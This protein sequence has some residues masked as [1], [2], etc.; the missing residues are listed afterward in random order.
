MKIEAATRLKA[1]DERPMFLPERLVMIDCEMTGLDP[2]TDDLLQVA[3]IKLV[4][5][6][7]GQGYAPLPLWPIFNLYIRTDKEPI[8]AFALEHM[9]EVYEKC[10]ASTYT[11]ADA[12]PLLAQWMSGWANEVSPTG[13]CVS[14]DILFLWEKGVID[15]SRFEGDT[16]IP[17]TFFYEQFDINPVKA[18]ARHRVGSKFDKALPLLP[19]AHDA[20]VDCENQLLELNAF[21]KVLIA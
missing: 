9:R 12:R 14:T 2:R 4:W 18:L 19:G 16:S 7:V 10:R 17:G 15:L 20:L 11:L 5:D 3:A 1:S 8:S 21:I 6:P 13:D